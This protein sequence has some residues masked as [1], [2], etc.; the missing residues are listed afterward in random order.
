MSVLMTLWVQ[1]DP[2]ELEKRAAADPAGMR[3]IADKAVEHD[4]I[5]HRFY[6]SDG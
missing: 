4:L 3:A 2:G 5:A 1:G 6:G